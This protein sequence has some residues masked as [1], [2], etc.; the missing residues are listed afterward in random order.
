MSSERQTIGSIV[1][2]VGNMLLGYVL[3]FDVC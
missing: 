2:S 3:V 1:P